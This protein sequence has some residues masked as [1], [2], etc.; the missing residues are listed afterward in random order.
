M[1]T[2]M[3]E[4]PLDIYHTKTTLMYTTPPIWR[5]VLVPARHDSGAIAQ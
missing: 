2:K 5:R 3:L 1:A 4:I